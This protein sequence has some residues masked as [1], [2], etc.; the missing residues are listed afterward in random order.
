MKYQV[1][2]LLSEEEYRALKSDIAENGVLV[3][4]EYDEE[5]N[6]LDGYHRAR[7][8]KELGIK[9]FPY[10]VRRGMTE[11][12]KIEHAIRLNC[13]RRHLTREQRQEKAKELRQ[14]GWSYRR[15]A[16]VLG[17]EHSTIIRWLPETGG[18]NAP[19]NQPVTVI[20]IDGKEYPAKR[21]RPPAPIFGTSEK[22]KETI[23]RILDTAEEGDEK[24]KD[25]ADRIGKGFATIRSAYKR[26]TQKEEIPPPELPEGQYEIILADPP[27]R[28]EFSE[29][30][31][32]AIENQYPTMDLEQIK[33][34]DIPVADN[35]VLFLW[36]TAPKLEEA[37]QVLNAWGFTYK[38]CAIWDKEIIGMGYWFRGQHELLLVGV[39]GKFKTPEPT[40][41][42][43]SVFRQK[44]GKHSK[45]PE[46]VHKMLEQMFPDAKK[47][48]LFAREARP[49]WG[50]WGNEV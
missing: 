18:A 42:F 21:E 5:G 31:M 50:A 2:P 47:I 45:K 23:T 32:R 33:T 8:C 40:N 35:A 41:R 46:V 7:A 1:M 16:G 11:G 36:S 15:I 17:V 48:E 20:G 13:N 38:T 4:I 37:L 22:Q 30:S 34:L 28:Y 9:D 27:W 14:R 25:L 43:P 26:M 10:L 6:I 44:R 3:P 12:E 39:K 29:T 49:G 24:A 19:P